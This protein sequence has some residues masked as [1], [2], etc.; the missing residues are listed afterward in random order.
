MTLLGVADTD[1]VLGILAQSPAGY[2]TLRSAL[3]N[4]LF[5]TIDAIDT[6]LDKRLIRRVTVPGFGNSKTLYEIVP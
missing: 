2:G 5:R 6:L 4:N 1:L 3:G